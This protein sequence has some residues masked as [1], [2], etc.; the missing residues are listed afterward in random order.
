MKAMAEPGIDSN[1]LCRS[2]L[3]QGQGLRIQREDEVPEKPRLEE[4]ALLPVALQRL[5]KHCIAAIRRNGKNRLTVLIN[6]KLK[7]STSTDRAERVQVRTFHLTQS[8]YMQIL[9]PMV[10]FLQKGRT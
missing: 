10:S 2:L 3:P 5:D 9:P 6:R 1:D 7:Q 4:L 8:N